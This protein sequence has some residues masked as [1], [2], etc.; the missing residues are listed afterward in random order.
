M[1][2]FFIGILCFCF[3]GQ[4][5]YAQF[6]KYFWEK[7]LRFDFYH[8]GDNRT[9]S[10]YFDELIEEPYWA[11]SKVALVDTTGYGNQMFK[12][13]DIATDEV[14]Y[15]RSYC[16]LFNEWQ[17]TDEAGRTHKC[18]PEGVI[19]PYPKND[20]RLELYARNRQGCF[21]KKFEHVI[22]VKDCFIK[23]F[24][25]RYETFE[26]MY[27]GA[28][29]NKVDIVLLPEGY[30]TNEKEKFRQACE[31]FVREFFSYSPFK[32][33]ALQF[34]VR[35][36]WV[37][38]A[39]S[40]VTMP[41]E[42]VWR[43]TAL[44]ASFYTFGAERYQ[45]I[46]DFQGVRDVAAH[47]PYEYIYILSNTQK[48]GG[49]GI[50]NFYGISAA[51]HP[52][53]TGKIYVHEFGHVLL[54]LGDEYGENAPYSD[55]YPEGVEPWEENLT[56][57]TD[58]GRKVIWNG[59]LDSAT[60]IPTPLNEKKLDK[61]GVYEGGGYAAKGVYRPWQNCLMNNLHKTD[62]FCPVCTDAIVRYVD[63]LCR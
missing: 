22:D 46:E 27:N 41:G 62:C 25:P 43:Q 16:T 45:M 50:F 34:N 52:T 55:M 36:V 6:E 18:M 51:N 14:I 63:W 48:Y 31:G 58:F 49:G 39:E 53:R 32:E 47:V 37:P 13:V 3:V 4:M 19:F 15:S 59:L 30:A 24:T 57:L 9:E 10:Y 20:V 42:Q 61:V 56:T 44:K 23:K 26:V 54:G 11:G 29:T 38:S 28:P 35:A 33:K 12:I 8:C 1:S 21:E 2:R 5:G 60:P 40:G 7:T 17:T